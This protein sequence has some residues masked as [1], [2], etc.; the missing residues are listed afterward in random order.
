MLNRLFAVL[1]WFVLMFVI[2]GFVHVRNAVVAERYALGEAARHQANLNKQAHVLKERWA[3]LTDPA[4]LEAR[5]VKELS[6]QVAKVEQI[7]K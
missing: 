4:R 6:M 5:A 7:L 3:R 2:T 1:G